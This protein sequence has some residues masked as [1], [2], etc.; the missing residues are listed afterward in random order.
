MGH[1]MQVVVT[2]RWN[3]RSVQDNA[4]LR[5]LTHS[6]GVIVQI[7]GKRKCESGGVVKLWPEE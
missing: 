5:S 4:C 2:W 1:Q 7:M 6:M 3:K